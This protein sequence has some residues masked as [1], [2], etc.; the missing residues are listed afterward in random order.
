MPITVCC[1]PTKE[2]FHD[3]IKG[4]RVLSCSPNDY[5]PDLKLNNYHNFTISGSN[6]SSLQLGL[7]ANLIIEPDEK[8]K[9]PASYLLVGFGGISATSEGVK[10][11]PRFEYEI[12]SRYMTKEQAENVNKAYPNFVSMVL[13]KQE[14]EIDYH[15]IFNVGEKRLASYIDKVKNDCNTILFYPVALSFGINSGE[16]IKELSTH[17]TSPGEFEYSYNNNPYYVYID[18]LGYSFDKAD[19]LALKYKPE[20]VD[21]KLRCEYGCLD[22]LHLNEQEGDTRLNVKIL[23]NEAK[24][25]VPEAKQHMVEA[26]KDSERIHYDEDTKTASIEATYQDELLIAEHIRDRINSK[27]GYMEYPMNWQNFRSVDGF[28]CTDEQME[29]LKIVG[30]GGR[31]GILTGSGGSGKTSSVK[32]LIRFIESEG[33]SYSL[34]APTGVAAKRMRESTGRPASTIHMFLAKDAIAGQYVIVDEFS[35]VSVNLLANLLKKIGKEP[36]L[37]FVCDEAQLA[38]IS[39]GNVVQD[40]IDCGLVPRA[41]LT[42]IFRYGI[43]GIATMATDT[44]FGT[45]EHLYDKFPDFTYVPINSNPVEQVL[46]EYDKLIE[47]G[48]KKDDILILTPYNTGTKGTYIINNE[49]QSKYSAN[50][51]TPVYYERPKMGKIRFKVGDRVVNTHN[52]YHMPALDYDENGDEIIG[53]MQCMNGDFG[54]VRGWFEEDGKYGLNIEFDNG[55][56]RV[57]GIDLTNILL[58]TSVTVH[59]IQGAQ[60]KAVIV[61]IDK[62]HKKLLSRNILYV[63]LSRAQETMCLIADEGVLGEAL[64]VQENLERDTNLGDML[65]E[66]LDEQV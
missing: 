11:D 1:T 22:I 18:L 50:D 24:H 48:Y 44:R 62:E 47:K 43:G 31:I 61:L 8:S 30:E 42:K 33:F 19:S 14:T 63:A 55:I 45:L 32:A 36:N 10:V 59:R 34:L 28:E 7:E 16:Q 21:S 37:I 57:M 20:L 58:G 2:L 40:L 46:L 12:L 52:N 13:N 65:K 49:I 27:M 53:E 35:M 60:A 38:S 5:N 64:E 26:I 54:T 6:L 56:A 3:S 41:N 29:I 17:F 4:W 25:L 51:Y 39:C 66:G 15:K 23:A 9:Y